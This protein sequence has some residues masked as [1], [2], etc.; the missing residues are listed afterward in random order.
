[1]KKELCIDTVKQLREKYGRL[2]GTVLH[3]DRGCQYTSYRQKATR[4]SKYM[5]SSTS[6][7]DFIGSGKLYNICYTCVY[8]SIHYLSVSL[9]RL[10]M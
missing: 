7:Y 1:M 10:F 9:N 5:P 3:S 4:F 8:V 2:E 6:E